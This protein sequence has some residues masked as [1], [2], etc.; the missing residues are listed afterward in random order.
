MRKI[1]ELVESL[2]TDAKLKLHQKMSTD[3]AAYKKLLKELLI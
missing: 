2:Q 1:N 3:Q